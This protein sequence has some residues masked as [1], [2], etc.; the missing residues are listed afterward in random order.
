M[1]SELW[2][3]GFV[4]KA[5]DPATTV[6]LVGQLLVTA[7]SLFGA[8][9]L[10]LRQLR[11]ERISADNARRAEDARVL[12]DD[13]ATLRSAL[14][15][16]NAHLGDYLMAHGRAPYAE[17]TEAIRRRGAVLR[18]GFEEHA[19]GRR[20]TQLTVLWRAARAAKGDMEHLPVEAIGQALR[21]LLSE[22][23]S[24]IGQAA[25]ELR[26]WDGAST[27]PPA[28][29]ELLD[30]LMPPEDALEARESWREQQ[31]RQLVEVAH[32]RAGRTLKVTEPPL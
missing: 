3:D 25:I 28:N 29:Q 32:R 17:R 31:Q 7:L 23:F 27:L 12:A 21:E 11:H 30:G 15:I 4:E 26:S 5:L 22:S 10:F 18:L 1:T 19:L 13:I 24:A 20:L 2:L 16:S 8:F 6:D 9:V 14:D